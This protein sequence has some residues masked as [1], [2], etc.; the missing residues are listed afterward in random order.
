[1]T[2]LRRRS[3]MLAVVPI[4][5]LLL[6]G[7]ST[8]GSNAALIGDEVVTV[9][10]LERDI[11]LF[12]FLTRLSGTACGVQ[13]GG[14]SPDAA[15]ARF[16]LTSDIREE[17]AKVYALEHDLVVDP[18]DVE[19]AITQ[20]EGGLGGAEGLAAQLESAGL[21]RADVVALAERLLL[22]NVVQQAVV[23][24]RVDEA[25]L[26]AAY[27]SQLQTFTTVE[28]AHILLADEAEAE[29]IAATITAQ[30]FAQVARR[31][32]TDP[33][34]A[35]NG[36][37]LGAYAE[38]EFAS[39]FDTDFVAGALALEPGEISGLVQTQ[40]GWHLIYFVRRDVAAFDDV[41]EQLRAAQVGTVFEA[42]LLEQLDAANVEVNPRFGQLD[43]AT[44][45]VLAVRSTADGPSGSTRGSPIE[46]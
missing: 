39:Q 35:A 7:C 17:L 41:R 28:V 27:D 4:A 18:A 42:W 40:F 15:C 24:E 16:T 43:P 23:D 30:T 9:R 19:S 3:R 21:T 22:V 25:A 20:L 34:S 32:S 8:T 38:A 33:G 36:G 11:E 1:M 10:E 12:G 29:R 14:E 44:G 37:N 45:Q 46:P 13:V 6:S 5:A 31:V 26:R 2:S